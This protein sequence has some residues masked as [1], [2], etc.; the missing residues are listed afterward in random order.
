MKKKQ[1][2]GRFL[3]FI[4]AF[5]M[6]FTSITVMPV[7]AFADNAEGS[8]GPVP[9]MGRRFVIDF[10]DFG[11]S[12]EYADALLAEAEAVVEGVL[13]ALD[14]NAPLSYYTTPEDVVAAVAHAFNISPTD[15]GPVGLHSALFI[16]DE[17]GALFIMGEITLSIDLN[18]LGFNVTPISAVISLRLAL[19]QLGFSGGP[20][21]PVPGVPYDGYYE[22]DYDGYLNYEPDEENNDEFNY[23]TYIY[24]QVYNLPPPPFAE[25]A[26]LS[27]GSGNTEIRNVPIA[28]VVG[29]KLIL[30][31]D[32][33]ITGSDIPAEGKIVW[34]FCEDSIY[35][36]LTAEYAELSFDEETGI[37][38]ITVTRAGRVA[39]IADVIPEALPTEFYEV[40]L[41]SYPAFMEYAVFDMLDLRGIEIRIK[42]E[43]NETVLRYN[44]ITPEMIT[45][46]NG[47][48][49]DY[50]AD[51][52]AD[53][54]LDKTYRTV[55][56]TI[57]EGLYVTIDLPV[58][59]YA[60]DDGEYFALRLASSN[61]VN[62]GIGEVRRTGQ[63]TVFHQAF[64]NVTTNP[65]LG[66]DGKFSQ[67][68]NNNAL[69]GFAHNRGEQIGYGIMSIGRD[70]LIDSAIDN[71]TW[72][73]S[74]WADRNVQQD[75][76]NDQ[77]LWRAVRLPNG[78][79]AVL[80]AN[81]DESVDAFGGPRAMRINA[82]NQ[83]IQMPRID[84]SNPNWW[85]DSNLWFEI[86]SGTPHDVPTYL[87]SIGD[88]ELVDGNVDV[89]SSLRAG[90]ITFGIPGSP[91]AVE[92]VPLQW[93]RG[94][95][96]NGPWAAVDDGTSPVYIIHDDD[97][98]HWLRVGA[99]P[100]AP[101]VLG[102]AVFSAAIGPV[103]PRPDYVVHSADILS[104]R[105]IEMG[106]LDI[107]WRNRMAF[108]TTISHEQNAI[109]RPENFRLTID[110]EEVGIAIAMYY[111]FPVVN[112]HTFMSS[113]RVEN[114]EYWWD[115][116]EINQFNHPDSS[117]PLFYE[118]LNY[119]IGNDPLGIFEWC[120]I[121]GMFTFTGEAVPFNMQLQVLEPLPLHVSAGGGTINT[122]DV[123]YDVLYIPYYQFIAPIY[124]S[125]SH[126]DSPYSD[127]YIRIA[128]TMPRANALANAE[129]ARIMLEHTLYYDDAESDFLN[130]IITQSLQ[131]HGFNKILTGVGENAVFMPEFRGR[132]FGSSPAAGYGGRNN[133]TNA[134]GGMMSVNVFNHEVGHAID[135]FAIMYLADNAADPE[136]RVFFNDIRRRLAFYFAEIQE[137]DWFN[138]GFG[139]TFRNN[140]GEMFAGLFEVW[141]N[142]RGQNNAQPTGRLALQ[143][144]HP[145]LYQ[146]TSLFLLSEDFPNIPGW[147]RPAPSTFR[148]QRTPRVFVPNRGANHDLT[149]IRY[150]FGS[151][152]EV[153]PA[154]V[155]QL[156]IPTAFNSPAHRAPTPGARP[157][158]GGQY[159][160][161]LDSVR[162]QWWTGSMYGVQ[163]NTWFDW[164]NGTAAPMRGTF[165]VTPQEFRMPD[166]TYKSVY[167]ITA[168]GDDFGAD[169]GPFDHRFG[170][171]LHTLPGVFGNPDGTGRHYG[172]SSFGI[173]NP[174]LVDAP[175]PLPVVRG[176]P[177]NPDNPYQLWYFVGVQGRY[178]QIANLGM[179]LRGQQMVI[180]TRG[181]YAPWSGGT[182]YLEP[183]QMNPEPG[184]IMQIVQ[185]RTTPAAA[186]QNTRLTHFR[187]N[188]IPNVRY[189]VIMED[190]WIDLNED[191]IW[192]RWT[193]DV[194]D[195]A[196][197]GNVDNFR[198]VQAGEYFELLQ[199]GSFT[200]GN[201]T[202]LQLAEPA[203][204][205][206]LGGAGL[207]IQFEG[208]AYSVS[209]LPLNN[210]RTFN[211]RGEN[212]PAPSYEWDML[213]AR[214]AYAQNLL[215]MPT[216]VSEDG[217]DVWNSIYWVNRSTMDALLNSVASA[218]ATLRPH[219]AAP[220]V[221]SSDIV[222]ASAALNAAI[223]QFTGA[224]A[225]GLYDNEPGW[226]Y[227]ELI[228]ELYELLIH[229]RYIVETTYVSE[230][231][232]NVLATY[233]WVI[234]S[235]MDEIEQ[236]IYSAEGVI[237]EP[238]T[239]AVV[240]E[241]INDLNNT[242]D[243]VMDESRWGLEKI[244]FL[245]PGSLGGVIG[246][247]FV[248]DYDPNA[249]WSLYHSI[250]TEHFIIFW[251]N[252]G[253]W[254][255][256][257][258]GNAPYT[259][260]D[261]TNTFLPMDEIAE[262]HD[263][264]FEFIRD[265][266]GWANPERANPRRGEPDNRHRWDT[267]RMI[268][269]IDYRNAW[270]ASGGTTGTAAAPGGDN[271]IGTIWQSLVPS[272][273]ARYW[274]GSV[275]TIEPYSFPTFVHEIGHAFQAMSR[276]EYPVNVTNNTPGA[277]GVGSLG[278]I[279]SQH[280]VWQMYP[281]WFYMEHHGQLFMNNTHRGF[282]HPTVQWSAPML[283]EYW[284]YL[285]GSTIAGRLN[286]Q[287]VAGLQQDIVAAYI[288]YTS[289]TQEQFNDEVFDASRR[290]VTW[291]LPRIREA[292][293]PFANSDQFATA[294]T[295]DG[296]SDWYRISPMRAPNSYGFNAIRLDVPASGTVVNLDFQGLGHPDF[297]I[298]AARRHLAG[299][300]YGFAAMTAEGTRIYGPINSASYTN[301][302]GSTGFTIPDDTEYL[303]LVVTGAP[304][305]HWN[306]AIGHGSEN[307]GYEI[308]L[309]NAMFHD[310]VSVTFVG[311]DFAMLDS[312]IEA[313]QA[314]V[315]ANYPAYRWEAMQTAF[316]AALE[317]RALGA[318]AEQADVNEANSEL[319]IAI[320][321]LTGINPEEVASALSIPGAIN[322]AGG[323][324]ARVEHG[325][326]L[327]LSHVH[328]WGAGNMTFHNQ[329]AAGLR[330]GILNGSHWHTHNAQNT[331]PALFN[332][333]PNDRHTIT[334]T[335]PE[336]MMVNGTRIMWWNDAAAGSGTG[337]A[338]PGADTFVEYWNGSEWVRI[339]QTITDQ[340]LGSGVLGNISNAL[341]FNNTRWNG[342]FF[343]PVETTAF[344]INTAR[345]P[346]VGAD[347]GIGA[348]Q[349]EIFG[350]AAPPQPSFLSFNI[351]NNNTDAQ[352]PGLAGTI[353]MWT[354]LDGVNSLVRFADLDITAVLEDNTCAMEF[355]RINRIW[356]NM[357][358]LN[359]I[360][361]DK[362]APWQ[363]IYFTAIYHGQVIEF[364][365]TNN[366]YLSA[367]VFE[368][369]WRESINV[370]FFQGVDPVIAF[371]IPLASI[372]L[373][374]DGAEVGDIR[375]Y[376][377]NIAGW[378][379]ET[380]AVFINKLLPW[381]EATLIVE[382]FGQTWERTWLNNMFEPEP[383][384]EVFNVRF[385]NFFAGVAMDVEVYDG[386]TLA[387]PTEADFTADVLRWGLDWIRPGRDFTGNW[388]AFIGGVWVPFTD[389]VNNEIIVTSNITLMPEADYAITYNPTLVSAV[390][391]PGSFVSI[392]ETA[393]NS[394]VW[395]LTFNTVNTFSDGKVMLAQYQVNLSG[396]NANLT[397]EY[398]FGAGH[399]LEGYALR[400][401][402]RDNGSNIHRLE[403][404]G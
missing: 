167:S 55:I 169:G 130:G 109:R 163:L 33:Y 119:D 170:N 161:I 89:L 200:A 298:T 346:G 284:T 402:I 101:Y 202:R 54:S 332:N 69:F 197:A 396:N 128:G 378:Q 230:N 153:E 90:T 334:M 115:K 111:E 315:E 40:E 263:R 198:V 32:V 104:I 25:T 207:S 159:F 293:A 327:T 355:V 38:S 256:G 210:Q 144:Y 205:T 27:G 23:G 309:E 369:D 148:G 136:M 141:F 304:T 379:T 186:A 392:T 354:Q 324:I 244:T 326:T 337:V 81:N 229:A 220:S 162:Y 277:P 251:E 404:I 11:L 79:Y 151:M 94:E 44:D 192:I 271:R 224:R 120:E 149:T 154:E 133:F 70:R 78:Y 164:S 296:R 195:I 375:D 317:V 255:N 15:F 349:W 331:D 201:I 376:T 31:G 187:Y 16:E 356:N 291:D 196:I 72:A 234:Q 241:V 75:A 358:Y 308:R 65:L 179:Q 264:I 233:F 237:S 182:Y 232:A 56:I 137:Q 380:S 171:D 360:D 52:I 366:R 129:R 30:G 335:W 227:P 37:S 45:W 282:L 253:T 100:A 399:D 316:A 114:W 113:I 14:Y 5:V 238:L 157:Y 92:N 91:I 333:D 21:E 297:A 103:A 174:D 140:R 110:G 57:V 276:I 279:Q 235:V 177:H 281:G 352:V 82:L 178:M 1:L 87:V 121:D 145:E 388:L 108:D 98:G 34:S 66:E 131:R 261:A 347:A 294:F 275:T 393:R 302:T 341:N 219:L 49:L 344:R 313:A 147:A 50:R 99:H 301:P 209:G 126:P 95:T 400:F 189:D 24:E 357:D 310:T 212:W 67:N 226:E 286:R 336:P 124:S 398:V 290:F 28:G 371:N 221:T 403:L 3:G 363:N 254:T 208:M 73:I 273:P 156:G 76:A 83:N 372:T 19:E 223:N 401:D 330:N 172:G 96:E 368:E 274:P 211:F 155:G 58:R 35:G 311:T 391:D 240:L 328:G 85:H 259:G 12:Q 46:E 258:P 194:A 359:F 303:W 307:W 176:M 390:T 105:M 132:T 26:N 299:W 203:L 17:H 266:I 139:S 86:E 112:P 204:A 84:L 385:L 350:E 64:A 260:I 160:K 117:T 245:P 39:L 351:F 265:D 183:W 2:I 269:F 239:E 225:L 168:S 295:T 270:H 116:F 283:F 188:I 118:W 146:L 395:V 306:G 107:R 41:Y 292:N 47:R 242:I 280:K 389:I 43:G 122:M 173:I 319:I 8:A 10:F 4:V 370:R 71:P 216:E 214:T 53:Q 353:R 236:A 181:G 36:F 199:E 59:R 217:L 13:Y 80:Y 249:R 342:A 42:G 278:E 257:G 20:A 106:W 318:D 9:D 300:R 248:R 150:Q 373:I 246:N 268:S 382:I 68:L 314:R 6:A 175:E 125:V 74:V 383:A 51:F 285:H 345:A 364:T 63:A 206:M 62:G 365:L 377:L 143:G 97:E 77:L 213:D 180:S 152:W 247:T 287:G 339:N 60:F 158:S 329:Q 267:H 338:P 381:Q 362:N 386:D 252:T 272:R 348:V 343:E 135:G 166:G 289:I 138:P 288:R 340:G 134:A 387:L 231:G 102:D 142:T 367:T 7:S 127:I 228:E 190:V 193:E 185:L 165:L 123:V 305:Q 93:Y 88:I 325:G 215:N 29:T 374:I 321:G 394:R 218:R 22:N 61:P 384:R 262:A 250:V 320:F 322:A 184:A 222:N 18:E 323:N 312:S 361:V 397:G 48:N 243:L 191:V